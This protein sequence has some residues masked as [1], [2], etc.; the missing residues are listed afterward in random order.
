MGIKRTIS[1][2]IGGV[3]ISCNAAMAGQMYNIDPTQ[4]WVKAYVPTWIPS[5]WGASYSIGSNGQLVQTPTLPTWQTEWNRATF[6][7]SGSFEGITEW[8]PWTPGVGHF[9]ISQG[10]FIVALPSPEAFNPISIFTFDK[11]TGSV[12]YDSGPCSHDPFSGPIP[13]LWLCSGWSTGIP[14]SLSGMFDGNTLNIEGSTG[15]NYTSF[16]FST[17]V[18]LTPPASVDTNNFPQFQ[19]Y[20]YKIVANAVP[21]PGTIPLILIGIAAVVQVGNRRKLKR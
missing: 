10:N 9:T 7:L 20:E 6:S 12:Y 17:Y 14:A 16:I 8:S 11:P 4:S 13:G 19:P 1:A 2:V 15:G 21:E 18:G 3:I 5:T